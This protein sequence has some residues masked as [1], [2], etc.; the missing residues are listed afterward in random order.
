MLTVLGTAVLTAFIVYCIVAW[1]TLGVMG[2]LALPDAIGDAAGW[3][4]RTLRPK[5]EQHAV[6][7]IEIAA[8]SYVVVIAGIAFLY[9]LGF[10]LKSVLF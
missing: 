6:D 1:G 4:Y 3:I 8:S 2:V 5:A 7:Q 9:G 10:V